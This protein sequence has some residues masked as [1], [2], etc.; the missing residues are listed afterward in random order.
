MIRVIVFFAVI[1]FNSIA[2]SQ[3]VEWLTEIKRPL[4]LEKI[5]GT[6]ITS[7]GNSF[8]TGYIDW[9]GAIFGNI[10]V[11]PTNSV[12]RN[13]FLAKCNSLGD[14]EWVKT[15]GGWSYNQ[16]NA[17]TTDDNGNVYSTGYCNGNVQFDSIYLPFMQ[18]PG[19]T[20]LLKYNKDGTIKWLNRFEGN[21]NLMPA[22]QGGTCLKYVNG[23][24]YDFGTAGTSNVQIYGSVLN[25]VHNNMNGMIYL[26]KFDTSGNFIWAKKIAEGF[27]NSLTTR[28]A[29][30]IGNDIIVTGYFKY[31]FAYDSIIK[32]IPFNNYQS[33]I[34]K[35]DSDGNNIWFKIISNSNSTNFV[36]DIDTDGNGNILATG[37]YKDTLT[38]DGTSLLN[39]SDTTYNSFICKL[40]SIGNLVWIKNISGT[41]DKNSV[42][43]GH[44]NNNIYLSGN[45]YGNLNIDNF[46]MLSPINYSIF[47]L[48][49]DTMGNIINGENYAGSNY[50]QT[51][52]MG[53]DMH[54][55]LYISGQ[56]FH[57]ATIAQYQIYADT[58][59]DWA[60]STDGYLFK[61]K[62]QTI[63][64][65]DYKKS[66]DNSI[67]FPNPNNG[68][69]SIYINDFQANKINKIE[70]FN[71]H[72]DKIKDCEIYQQHSVI[73]CKE[74]PSGIYIIK[75]INDEKQFIKKFIIAKN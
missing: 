39:P 70:I 27:D 3:S 30:V 32:Y 8:L 23:Y 72:G 33:F 19:E 35:Y 63:G 57:S 46:T 62:P 59:D 52:G 45:F 68:V 40:D 69:F 55:Y 48:E 47:I 26:T 1:L 29:I 25:I 2:Y 10:L 75:L 28:D 42:G 71:I 6:H 13:Y 60:C 38:I 66:L 73:N 24:L 44:N 74:L 61:Y 31:N 21:T 12:I 49:L 11:P 7:D 14:F 17:V 67:L 16:G 43:L 18:A 65:Q 58:I 41:G 15:G 51:N 34:A 22:G 5:Q 53:I 4:N 20:F 56:Y 50:I 64:I 9:T 36:L 54:G 37:V